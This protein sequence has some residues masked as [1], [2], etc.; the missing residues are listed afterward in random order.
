MQHVV[1]S[2]RLAIINA[3]AGELVSTA[4]ILDSL[5]PELFITCHK[6]L[7]EASLP[8][9]LHM[10]YMYQTM[11]ITPSCHWSRDK[12][13]MCAKYVLY[14]HKCT[15]SPR[16]DSSS[17]YLHQHSSQP[18]SQKHH[19]TTFPG[20]CPTSFPG[21]HLT[22]FPGHC[23]PRTPPN[24]ILRMPLNLI[25]GTLPNLIPRTPLNHGWGELGNKASILWLSH[26]LSPTLPPPY[27]VTH[28][29]SPRHP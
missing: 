12:T 5:V 2:M 21:H 6:S 28:T 27:T 20:H 1:P 16:C 18:H 15:S 22:T 13:Y 23:P 4:A 10:F 19:L 26:T 17:N 11:N 9:I 25:P 14:T 7:E 8:T 24:L 3:T 29:L